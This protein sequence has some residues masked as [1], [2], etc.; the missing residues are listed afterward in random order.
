VGAALRRLEK[1]LEGPTRDL[2]VD[3]LKKD[4]QRE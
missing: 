3:E 2:V 4:L 1:E